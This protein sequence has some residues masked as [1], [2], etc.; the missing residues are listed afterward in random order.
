MTV[1]APASRT[2]QSFAAAN[3]R[4]FAHLGYWSRSWK[5]LREN[6]LGS[7]MGLIVV[8]EIIIALSAPLLAKYVTHYD[9]DT[10]DL[11]RL[12]SPPNSQHW[13][14][15][16][17]LGRDTLTRLIY[18]AQVSLTVASLTVTIAVLVGTVVG[19]AAGFYGG[20]LDTLFMRVVD[21]FLAIPPIFFF[22]MLSILFRPNVIGISLVVAS[23][24]WVGLARLVRSEVLATRHL[25]FVLA[26]RSIGASNWRLMA[27][28]IFPAT[29]PVILVMASLAVAQV[30]LTEAALSF[31]GLGILP[32]AP[33]WGNMISAAQ[34]YFGRAVYLAIFPGVAIFITVLAV[35]VF[36]NA[37]RDALDPSLN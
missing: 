33:S 26:A 30:I 20:L 21:V 36:G 27:R 22:I 31:L 3:R 25:D 17:D 18:G 2:G 35:N 32:P 13:L 19:V 34:Q 14:G 28:H 23:I 8:V 16:D 9:P 12:F 4:R 37:V 24:S 10:Q 1:A 7:A 6:R 29:V 11:V 15:T 5:R